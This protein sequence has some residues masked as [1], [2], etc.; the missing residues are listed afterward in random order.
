[1]QI[2]WP[3]SADTRATVPRSPRRLPAP[4][5]G[6]IN[7]GAGSYTLRLLAAGDNPYFTSAS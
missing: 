2:F 5:A 1:M 3:S 4:P 6:A 7:M